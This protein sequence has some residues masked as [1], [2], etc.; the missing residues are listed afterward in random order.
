M[1][2]P[3]LGWQA[4]ESCL[5]PGGLMKIALYG[6]VSRRHIVEARELIAKLGLGSSMEEMVQFRNYKKI[7]GKTLSVLKLEQDFY[8]LSTFR[9][10]VFHV[11]EYRFTGPELQKCFS[12]LGLKFIGF[13]YPTVEVR[14][15][16]EKLFPNWGK[17]PL[18]SLL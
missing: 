8:T 17:Q 10:L 1:K 7:K 2:D 18:P 14:N 13:E 4:L 6:E 15:R 5:K 16:S 9:D 3:F 12:D 11:Q